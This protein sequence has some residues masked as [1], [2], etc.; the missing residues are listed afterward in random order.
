MAGARTTATG[1]R[2]RPAPFPQGVIRLSVSGVDR[3]VFLEDADALVPLL[4]RVLVGRGIAARRVAEPDAGGPP[5]ATVRAERGGG[6]SLQ[7]CHL[8]TPLSG[9]SATEAVCGLIADLAEA[10]FIGRPGWLGLHCGA[11]L[12]GGRLVAVTGPARA[13]KSTL[14]ARLAAE[15]ELAIVCDDVL[16]V[17]PQGRAHALGA[18]LR[19]RLPLA[20]GAGPLARLA[21]TRT[22]LADRHYGYIR[23]PNLL[24][25]GPVAPPGAVV[26][27]DRRKSGRAAL[28]A[29]DP[30]EAL[31]FLLDR[32]IAP[33]GSG[34]ARLARLQALLVEVPCLR[35]TYAAL[36]DAVRLVRAALPPD[37]TWPAMPLRPARPTGPPLAARPAAM[38]PGSL[39]RA[40]GIEMRQA[41]AD[42]FLSRPGSGAV[43]RL[44]P[45]AAA[46]W[47]MLERPA[48]GAEIAATLVAAFPAADPT[49]IAADVA[50]ILAELSA[51]ALLRPVRRRR[52]GTPRP[53]P[54]ALRASPA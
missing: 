5:L 21:A 2:G 1:R 22:V 14:I 41:G 43:I 7:S 45:T 46:I 40:A 24:P 28:A 27:L 18:A 6:Y 31:G 37:G 36:E 34:A 54:L 9:L 17:D 26:V 53:S 20:A 42:L 25:A 13:G 30:G 35:L 44:N 51:A 48:S 38:P 50:A 39:R 19:L 52:G 16:P 8:G 47:R 10:A 12:S 49:R 11:F 33:E 3:P 23:P 4:R 32:T 15:P 29:L